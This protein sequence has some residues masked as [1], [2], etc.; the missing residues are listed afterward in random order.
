[1]TRRHHT[2]PAYESLMGKDLYHLACTHERALQ[3]VERVAGS[4]KI[5]DTSGAF[6]LKFEDGLIM[7]GRRMFSASHASKVAYWIES[8][9][10][11]ML[12]AVQG[13]YKSA[14]L[15]DWV[16]GTSI[17]P[18][19]SFDSRTHGVC[20]EFQANLH[21]TTD[22]GIS[23]TPPRFTLEE[24]GNRLA[25]NCSAL[26]SHGLL[27]KADTRQLSELAKTDQIQCAT[28]LVHDDLCGENLI[29]DP[30]GNV[31]VIDNEGLGVGFAPI[32][33]ARTVYRWQMDMDTERLYLQHYESVCPA[34]EFRNNR[35]FWI[36][37]VLVESACYRMKGT[38]NSR[39]IPIRAIRRLLR[40]AG[41]AR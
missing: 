6:R 35:S 22:P 12:P 9:K 37:S 20:A 18:C 26:Y 2:E 1:M 38:N 36:A 10:S 16:P 3:S 34:D 21:C 23:S 8:L 41:R 15:L 14:L 32:D 4:A 13:R 5:S 29:R 27:D 17:E 30:V 19:S 25:D 31:R 7:K 24:L 11:P 39:N 33:I 40:N 28:S